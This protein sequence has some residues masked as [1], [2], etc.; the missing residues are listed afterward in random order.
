MIYRTRIFKIVL[1]KYIVS[2]DANVIL[3]IKQPPKISWNLKFNLEELEKIS[4]YYFL[5]DDSWLFCHN[6]FDLL[7][8]TDK[9]NLKWYVQLDN[10][11]L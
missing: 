8:L 2:K 9:L 11:L 1:P 4:N 5:S 6:A 7:Y 3:I 10:Y